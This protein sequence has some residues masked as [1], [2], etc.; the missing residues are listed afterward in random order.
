MNMEFQRICAERR[1]TTFLVTHSI[2][3]AVILS[4]RIFV[5][6]AS[7]GRI[8]EVVDIDLPRSR[9]LDMINTAQFGEIVSHIRAELDREGFL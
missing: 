1:A 8:A 6:Q 7:P 3:E 5:M 4:D 2:P 9:A